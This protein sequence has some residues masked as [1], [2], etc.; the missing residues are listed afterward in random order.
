MKLY[1]VTRYDESPG[2]DEGCER[3]IVGVA[4][5]AEIAKGAHIEV[6]MD[7]G[8]SD[9]EV[10]ELDKFNLRGGGKRIGEVS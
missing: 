9:I 3:S 4:S 8:D 2:T 7:G 10:F 1:V 6:I 5:T